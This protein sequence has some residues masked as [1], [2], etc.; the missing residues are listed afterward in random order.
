MSQMEQASRERSP[1]SPSSLK[2]IGGLDELSHTSEEVQSTESTDSN[3]SAM[4]IHPHRH[5][6]ALHGHT[7]HDTGKLTN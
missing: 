1:F 4:W 2:A 6:L 3:P 5:S 7:P